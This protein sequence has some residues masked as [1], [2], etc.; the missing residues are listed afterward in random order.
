MSSPMPPSYPS[1]TPASVGFGQAAPEPRSLP[2]GAGV[3]WIGEGWRIFTA[4]PWPWIAIT[5]ILA[6]IMIAIGFIPVIGTFAHQL[7][8]PV[9]IGGVILGCHALARGEPLS[10]S[11]LF[12]G[13]KSPHLSPLMV[14]GL[15]NLA[16][17]LAVFVLFALIFVIGVGRAAMGDLLA[18]DVIQLGTETMMRL[19]AAGLIAVP[20]AVIAVGVL[21]MLW[22]FAPPLIVLDGMAPWAAMKAS[23]RGSLVNVVPFLVYGI[24]MLA[25]AVLASIPFALG[26]VVLAPVAM[27]SQYASWRTVFSRAESR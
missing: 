20:L 1:P 16:I 18:D 26:W 2:A 24:V 9:F 27:G 6:L 7:L 25:L 19:G 22:W 15:I 8:A 11:H 10:V 14:F 13:F 4:A 5:V 21:A 3:S 17:S 12:D 23:F